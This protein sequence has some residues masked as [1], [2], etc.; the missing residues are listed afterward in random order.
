[1]V[2]RV[3]IDAA[4]CVVFEAGQ[5]GQP[6]L[7]RCLGVAPFDDDD[8]KVPT[9][10][11]IETTIYLSYRGP[12]PAATKSVEAVTPLPICIG[13]VECLPNR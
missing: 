7:I 6:G 9:A 11:I 13:M 8:R 12:A 1:M 10:R 3:V 4:P 2:C 5:A